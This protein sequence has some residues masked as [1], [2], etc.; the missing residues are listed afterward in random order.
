MKLQ[1]ALDSSNSREAKGILEQISDLVDIVEVGTP[2]LMKEGVKVVTEI[3]NTYP[4]LE[5]LADLKIMDAGDIEASIGFEAGADIV[6]VLGVAHDVTIRR[7]V[8]QARTLNKQVM[9]DLIAVG[10]V[11]ERI[12][13]IDPIA[14]DYCCVHTA[15]DLQD[16]GIDP[17]REIQLVHAA[18]KQAKMAVA[19]GINP[20]ILPYILAYRPAVI[21]VGGFIANQPDPRQAA[22]EIRELL[23]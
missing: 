11:R 20:K 7:A 12:D 22:L 18:L 5:V 16:H 3:K 19:G 13:Q 2:L 14:P 15:F 17:L 10:D 4:Q 1:L 9:I 6:T 8:N 23:A 21:I